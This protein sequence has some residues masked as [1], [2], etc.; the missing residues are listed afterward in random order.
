MRFIC[1]WREYSDVAGA[2]LYER[3]PPWSRRCRRPRLAPYA[4]TSR[5]AAVRDRFIGGLSAERAREQRGPW[6]VA[7]PSIGKRAG[8]GEQDGACLQ[9]ITL[10]EWQ[11]TWRQHRRRAPS[12][13]AVLDLVKPQKSLLAA[14]EQPRRGISRTRAALS[15]SARSGG[16]GPARGV[17]GPRQRR[18]AALISR[19]RIRCRNDRLVGRP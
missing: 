10:P 1:R 14:Y 8:E 19:R 4:A 3:K 17:F 9:R 5:R 15:T 18:A 2:A 6:Y 13:P 7:G 12:T 11:T 16:C